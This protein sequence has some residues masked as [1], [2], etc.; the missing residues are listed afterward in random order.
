MITDYNDF[1]AAWFQLVAFSPSLSLSLMS[2]ACCME[3]NAQHNILGYIY[4]RSGV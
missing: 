1:V 4:N 2:H 3:H